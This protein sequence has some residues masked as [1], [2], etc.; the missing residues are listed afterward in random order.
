MTENTTFSTLESNSMSNPPQETQKLLYGSIISL[1]NSWDPNTFLYSD[2]FIKKAITC[3]NFS[4]QLFK[5][6]I[7]KE[8]EPGKR[9]ILAQKL[10]FSRCLFLICPVFS[11]VA[12]SEV[13]AFTDGFLKG[14]EEERLLAQMDMPFDN[15]FTNYIPF[16]LKGPVHNVNR[17]E[18]EENVDSGQAFRKKLLM[19]QKKIESEFKYNMDTFEKLKGSLLSFFQP[20]QLIHLNSGKFLVCEDY[21]ADFEK[22]SYKLSLADY[23][24]E[25]TIFRF[26]PAFKYQ[27]DGDQIVLSGE[28]LS[29]LSSNPNLRKQGFLNISEEISLYK[30]EKDKVNTVIHRKNS[31]ITNNASLKKRNSAVPQ[32]KE[33]EALKLPTNISKQ[34]VKR[35]ANVGL[36]EVCYWKINL[37]SNYEDY[38]QF[39][40][41]GDVIWLHNVEL[42][43]SLL[44]QRKTTD[45]KLNNQ[46][47]PS[48][49]PYDETLYPVFLPEFKANSLGFSRNTFGM[50]ILESEEFDKGG[51][52]QLGGKYRL[53]HLSSG[54]YLGVSREGKGDN[55][56]AGSLILT[57]KLYQ[58]Y[59]GESPELFEFLTIKAAN[60]GKDSL[61][62]EKRIL[63]EAFVLIRNIKTNLWVNCKGEEDLSG[64]EGLQPILTKRV[65]EKDTF[66]LY[67]A[68]VNEISELN[69]LLSSYPLLFSFLSVLEEV[70]EVILLKFL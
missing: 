41:S 3:R 49:S 67:S 50:W 65:T 4:P 35:E 12:K 68:S 56:N 17:K 51:F 38:N 7:T 37:Y 18:N 45:F 60:E 25:S 27:R 23:P 36:E 13:Q 15:A 39:L 11:N 30:Q 20:F 21:E 43:A 22:E 14:V 54:R 9:N 58:D 8:K 57:L 16:N 42:N 53:K 70:K 2:G 29:I 24:S 52:I 26:K 32:K 62:N 59:Q 61:D 69:I 1:S 6:L 40:R 34:I 28:T 48:D 33:G 19:F 46:D 47:F 31:S 63:K 10:N 66:R 5:K 55:I 64:N 44:I